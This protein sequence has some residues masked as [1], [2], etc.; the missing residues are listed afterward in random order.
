MD[1][2]LELET[3]ALREYGNAV[4]ADVST[5][6]DLVAWP[7]LIGGQIEPFR[8]QSNACGVDEELIAASLFDDL[9]VA[10]DHLHA[11]IGGSSAQ[12]VDHPAQLVQR[13]TF[14]QNEGNAQE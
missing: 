14:L 12:R 10:R 9:G 7:R 4:I 8:H 6:Q 3:L 2:R 5:E 1:W 13:K 11:R